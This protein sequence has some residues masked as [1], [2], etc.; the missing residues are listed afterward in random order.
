M[1]NTTYKQ[2]PEQL[3]RAYQTTRDN[4]TVQD[5]R[6][7]IS[8]AQASAHEHAIHLIVAAAEN[9]QTIDKTSS[10]EEKNG[11]IIFDLFKRAFTRDLTKVWVGPVAALTVALLVTSNFQTSNEYLP[12]ELGQFASCDQCWKYLQSSKMRG[13][14]PGLSRLD[15]DQRFAAKLGEASAKLR[16][17]LVS[18]PGS[19]KEPLLQVLNDLR[20]LESFFG[21]ELQ[22]S[23]TKPYASTEKILI[24]MRTDMQSN[25]HRSI[26]T[27]AEGLQLTT[28]FARRALLENVQLGLLSS[29]SSTIQLVAKL[30][31]KTAQQGHNL[32]VLKKLVFPGA[33]ISF[34]KQ[35]LD[36]IL[37]TCALLTESIER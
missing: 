10:A 31:S 22:R 8:A 35:E 23:M 3:Y 36:L 1:N 6:S 9:Q 7:L 26:F 20:Q 29:L 13:A 12:R 30:K 25:E 18:S 16:V 34:S 14:I 21:D 11:S 19:E 28:V 15:L 33:G 2:S 5:L 32:A 24:A 37:D 4:L 17:L 27:A